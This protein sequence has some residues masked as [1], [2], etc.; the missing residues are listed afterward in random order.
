MAQRPDQF[1]LNGS[2]PLHTG[3]RFFGG[4]ALS[5]ST[6]YHDSSVYG[7]DGTL[8]NMDPATDWVSGIGRR[9]IDFAGGGISRVTLSPELA[10]EYSQSFNA[11]INYDK[12]SEKYVAGFTLE[13]FYTQ[14][15]DAFI[16]Q[17]IGADAF[18]EVFEKQ[19]GQNATV[20]GVTLELR[21]NYD[22]KVQLETGL[23][24][25]TSRFEEEVQYIEGLEGIKDFIRT[26]NQYGVATLSITPHERW[27]ANINSV[28]TG[29]MIVPHSAGPP[30][31]LGDQYFMSTAV[32]DV[33]FKLAY[34]F[35]I[36][37]ISS[38]LEV[39]GGVKNVF[40]AYQNNFDI[41]KNRDSNFV[42]GPALPRSVFLGVKWLM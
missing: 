4:G 12:P 42:F 37:Q 5:G 21:A 38:N 17:P 39:Y 1:T 9:A 26:P 19:N 36:E 10:P 2:H 24:V 15:E 13:G 3:L 6:H 34:N 32:S 41:G 20:Q 16:L 27:N 29:P 8:V 25:Q 31:Q 22:R 7:T 14:L 18:G 11:S 28:Y 33:N 23:T 35:R 40:N 30:N